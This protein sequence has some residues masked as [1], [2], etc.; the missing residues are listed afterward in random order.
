MQILASQSDNVMITFP[1]HGIQTILVWKMKPFT[2]FLAPEPE[3]SSP[4]SQQLTTDRWSHTCVK[5]FLWFDPLFNHGN[6]VGNVNTENKVHSLPRLMNLIDSSRGI[7]PS[8]YLY[9]WSQSLSARQG[10]K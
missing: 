2:K 10:N 8:G 7:L 4:I 5:L 6:T 1:Y 3:G 9:V